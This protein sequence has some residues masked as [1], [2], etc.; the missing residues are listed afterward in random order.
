MCVCVSTAGCVCVGTLEGVK[1][2]AR[3]PSMDHHTWSHVTFTSF[4]LR[5]ENKTEQSGTLNF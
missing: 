5:S 2:R 1:C 4:Y 3:I